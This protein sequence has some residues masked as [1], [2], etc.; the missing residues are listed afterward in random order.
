L[1]STLRAYDQS[2][3]FL[4]G[5]DVSREELVKS[6][7]GAIGTIDAY[8]LP[9]ARGYSAM[10][11]HLIGYADADRQQYRTEL[12]NTTVEDFHAFAEVLSRVAADGDIV[13]LGAPS[14][15]EAAAAIDFSVTNVL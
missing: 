1:L 8:Q 13:V 9:D 2:A 15:I 4:R 14:V 12:L 11:R 7:I 10:V 5:L 3:S 6:I